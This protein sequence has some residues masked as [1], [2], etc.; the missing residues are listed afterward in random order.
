MIVAKSDALINALTAGP[1]AAKLNAPIL[2][3][4]INSVSVYHEDT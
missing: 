1:L 2:L 3:N 4:P